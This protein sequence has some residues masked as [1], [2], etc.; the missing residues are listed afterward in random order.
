MFKVLNMNI[1]IDVNLRECTYTCMAWQKVGIPCERVCAT[2]HEMKLDVDEYVDSRYKLPMQELIYFNHFNPLSNHN[3]PII[4][5]DG[6]VYDA[7]S[8]L[9]P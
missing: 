2:I 4:D 7:R 5:S 8:C 1:Y 6:C 3:M 9:Y